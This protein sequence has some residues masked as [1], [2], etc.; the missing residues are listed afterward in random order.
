MVVEAYTAAEAGFEVG[1][2]EPAQFSREYSKLFGYAP[3]QDANRLKN[4]F[5]TTI[6]LNYIR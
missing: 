4:S 2:R 5:R 3:K 1:Y 6:N